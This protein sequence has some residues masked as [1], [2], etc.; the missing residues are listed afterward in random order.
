M[1]SFD[2]ILRWINVDYRL[3]FAYNKPLQFEIEGEKSNNKE[4]CLG[5]RGLFHVNLMAE[6]SSSIH[7]VNQQQRMI[8]GKAADI[9]VA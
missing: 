9:K 8:V 7:I 3:G 1:S 2:M 6:Y 4:I 5:T